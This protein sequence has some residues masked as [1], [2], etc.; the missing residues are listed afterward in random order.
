MLVKKPTVYLTLFLLTLAITFAVPA[1]AGSAVVGSVADIRN[2]MVGGQTILPNTTLFSGDSLQVKDGVAVVALG[3]SSR[4]VFGHDTVA[5]FLR[6]ANEVTVLLDQG[7]VSLFHGEDSAPVRVK[8]GDISV[9][10]VAGFKT[11]GEV[12]TL[13]DTAVI[14][15]KEG[16]LHVEG[17]GTSVNV[18]KGKTI[19]VKT[20]TR[21][22][23]PQ[24]G[25]GGGG[26]P[27][28]GRHISGTTVW[29]GVDT[30]LSAGALI[31]GA[32]ALHNASNASTNAS[33]ASSAA[34]AAASAA[35]AAIS[36]ANSAASAALYDSIA[37]GCAL[38]TLAYEQGKASPYTPPGTAVCSNPS[39]W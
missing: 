23:Q 39:T 16:V 32:W 27:P 25:P 24:G 8:V 21:A 28:S 33:S 20:R 37:V 12:A 18:V 13:Y 34:A 29:G 22:P 6:D 35:Q 3:S 19:T 7:D 15:A 17:N 11:L 9:V 4:M 10:P 2:A 14:T 5:S 26:N 30:A 31:V 1:F 36:A 38:D